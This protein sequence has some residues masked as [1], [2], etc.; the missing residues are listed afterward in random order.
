MFIKINIQCKFL[1][2]F[3]SPYLFQNTKPKGPSSPC[4]RFFSGSAQTTAPFTA[5]S[6]LQEGD[7]K[8]RGWEWGY[9]SHGKGLYL[10]QWGTLG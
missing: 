2:L 1:I 8:G 10:G 5:W 9:Y 4:L 3:L 7:G 6:Q